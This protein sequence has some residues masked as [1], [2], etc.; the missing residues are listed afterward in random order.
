MMRHAAAV[1]SPAYMRFWSSVL[2][3]RLTLDLPNSMGHKLRHLSRD[4]E[5][6]IAFAAVRTVAVME[7]TL[8][9]LLSDVD[10]R[11]DLARSAEAADVL[12]ET[13]GEN[14]P[15][16][17]RYQAGLRCDIRRD[18]RSIS[19]TEFTLNTIGLTKRSWH[20]SRQDHTNYLCSLDIGSCRGSLY[21][22]KR[23]TET[24]H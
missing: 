17:P 5:P 20:P 24:H 16:S 6:K 11:K 10:D 8:L 14:D 23:S 21:L 13:T 3:K 18:G 7:R 9:D 19:V 4:H 1:Q 15:A 2:V 12:A 22:G